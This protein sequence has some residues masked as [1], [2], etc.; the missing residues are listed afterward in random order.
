LLLI[1]FSSFSIFQFAIRW[2]MF[3]ISL[4]RSLPGTDEVSVMISVDVV[5]S[6]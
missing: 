3:D 5:E 1:F 6:P 2:V 4:L